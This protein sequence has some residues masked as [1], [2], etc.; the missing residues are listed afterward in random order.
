MIQSPGDAD[1]DIVKVTVER[2][3]HCTTTSVGEDRF[4]DLAPSLLHNRQ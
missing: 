3:R 1:V 4:A 2:F